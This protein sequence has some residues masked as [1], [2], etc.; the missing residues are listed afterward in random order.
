MVTSGNR[1]YY[2][3]YGE[4]LAYLRWNTD[5][6]RIQPE[7]HSPLYTCPQGIIS[8]CISTKNE[9]LLLMTLGNEKVVL[10]AIQSE[11]V[12]QEYTGYAMNTPCRTLIIRACFGGLQDEFLALGNADGKIYIWQRSTGK[13]LKVFQ[14]HDAPINAVCWNAKNINPILASAG[15]DKKIM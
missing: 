14:A 10:F 5:M 1:L 9:N 4:T 6:E 11:T 12:I 2:I 15:D 8:L 3:C 13:Q 7:K